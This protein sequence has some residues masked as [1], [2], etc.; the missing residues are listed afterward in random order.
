MV[1]GLSEEKANELR[2]IELV[3]YFQQLA[4]VALGKLVNPGTNQAERHLPQAKAMIDTLRMLKAKSK[5]NVS[6]TEQKLID[7]VI[8]NLGLNYADEAAKPSAAPP[9]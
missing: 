6:D 9:T 5:G 8:L 3:Y 4:M 2:F 1:E 7:Q